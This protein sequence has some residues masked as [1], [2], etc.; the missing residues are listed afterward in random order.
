VSA[1]TPWRRATA[2][3]CSPRSTAASAEK[4]TV[5]LVT[6]PGSTSRGSTRSR[7]RHVSQRASAIASTTNSSTARSN[8]RFTRI[9]VSRTAAPPQKAQRQ[10][11][12]KSRPPAVTNAA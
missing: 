10:P 8:L 12:N 5:T 2:A 3:T 9:R 7:C 6:L 1:Q 4:I 11:G